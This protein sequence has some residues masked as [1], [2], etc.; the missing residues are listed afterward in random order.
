MAKCRGCGKDTTDAIKETQSENGML[1][2]PGP[3]H[4]QCEVDRLRLLEYEQTEIANECTP[5]LAA[6]A[7]EI[8]GLKRETDAAS[9]YI[10]G[11]E[12]RCPYTHE[13]GA[14]R[15]TYMKAAEACAALASEAGKGE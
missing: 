13:L 7:E 12:L 8:E 4:W 6:Q 2:A 5:Q 15:D 3:M 10:R 1:G 11:M 9:E 14:L